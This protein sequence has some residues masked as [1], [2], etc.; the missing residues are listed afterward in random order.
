M[1]LLVHNKIIK[2][3]LSIK[4][5]YEKVWRKRPT[6]LNASSSNIETTPVNT[7][8]VVVFRLQGLDGDATEVSF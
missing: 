7:P 1:E 3:D 6:D 4:Q 2:L 8:M 5:V